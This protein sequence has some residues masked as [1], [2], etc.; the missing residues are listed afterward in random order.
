MVKLTA[1]GVQRA[2]G[3]A[4]LHDGAG[5]YLRVAPSGAKAWVFRYQLGGKRRDM[6]IGSYPTISLADARQRAAE[7]RRQRHD[8]I[9]PLDAR[10]TRRQAQ[11]VAAA[12]GRTFR[13]CAVEYMASHRAGWRSAKHIDQWESTLERFAYPVIGDLPVAALDTGL[14]MQVLEPIWSTK[15]ETA[16]RIRGRIE[17]VLDAATARG[18]RGG[19]NPAQW[20]GNLVHLLPA[21]AKVRRTTHH[22][23]LPIDEVPGFMAE[24]RGREGV[25]ARALEFAILTAART[26]EVIGARWAE[27]DLAAKTWTVPAA[28]MKAAKEHRVPLCDAALR[29]LDVVRP[30]ALVHIGKPAANSQVFPG[31]RLALPMDSSVLLK[32]LERMGRGDITTHG[33]RSSF[34]DW[35]A[36]RTAFPREVVEMALA[37]AIESRVEAAYRRGDLFE[38]RRRLMAAWARFCGD[39]PEEDAVTPLPVAG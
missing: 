3:P 25:S 24:L 35:A 8:G 34:R 21:P 17:A 30:L 38:K 6:G 15:L 4:V 19:P 10:K 39:T 11:L 13:E 33:F 22:A 27:I 12:R 2:K 18:Y 7:H 20:K 26:N 29:V 16:S 28:R 1:I 32:L 37:H 9:D 23:S 14:V 31:Q 5:L 36:E